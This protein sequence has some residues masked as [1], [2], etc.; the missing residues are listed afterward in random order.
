MCLMGQ[1]E[2]LAFILQWMKL[3]RAS[4]CML[5]SQAA[6]GQLELVGIGSELAS[7]AGVNI[8][9]GSHPS[10]KNPVGPC[11]SLVW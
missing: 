4:A 8:S 5:Y 2:I 7:W 9:L 1:F 3:A 10:E 6:V 11:G